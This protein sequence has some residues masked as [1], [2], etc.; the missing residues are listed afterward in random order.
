M[1]L[2][3]RTLLGRTA[4]VIALALII[5]QLV[6]L[7][8]FRLYFRGPL[9]EQIAELA[10][11]QIRTVAL[12]M[13]V[14]HD[15]AREEFLDTLERREG[16]RVLYDNEGV[17]ASG[18]P[19]TPELQSFAGYVR[20]QLGRETEFF[21]QAQT[22]RA[23]WVRLGVGQEKFWVSIP[24][25]E[26]ERP[27][28]WL[29]IAS[30]TAS[31]LS[32]ILLAYVLVRRLNRPLAQ[33]S[34]AAASLGRGQYPRPI[35]SSGPA[36][37]QTLGHAFNQMLSDLK[38]ADAE[39]AVLLAGVSHDL[40]TPLTRMRLGIELLQGDGELKVDLGRDI[41]EM[42]AIV[43]QFLAFARGESDEPPLSGD[44]NAL[45]R[46]V[47]EGYV[48][49]G[50]NLQLERA[51][52]TTLQFRPIALKRALGNLIDNALKY[53]GG[54]ITVTTTSA[55]ARATISVLDRGPGIPADQVERMLRPFTRL[56]S[57]RTGATGAG[58]GLA[59]VERV[60]ALHGGRL[61]LSAR[62]GG[63][64]AARIELPL[65]TEIRA[66]GTDSHAAR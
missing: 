10:V 39:R 40:R 64:L 35:E 20:Q 21:V 24:R 62:D 29:W 32:A 43:S 7:Q 27:L 11:R 16:V 57:A 31:A 36:E 44:L 41:D 15:Q 5:S 25:K 23:L 58:L 22:G 37:I 17:L 3:P 46:E 38:R 48:R 8:A 47:C 1:R 59:I 42:E 51:G 18:D 13:E 61:D 19:Q 33:L 63:G 6:A 56:E 55:G 60:A 49:R 45:V 4:L 12:A 14:L 28:P 26:I 9:F 52:V 66:Q 65:T 54:D 53:G 34:A 2:A 30:A 50:V